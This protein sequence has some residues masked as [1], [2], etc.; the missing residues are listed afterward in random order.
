VIDPITGTTTICSSSTTQLNDVTP[1]G[2]WSSSDNAV[3][4]VDASGLV[5]GTGSGT[6]TISY[7]VTNV[8]NVSTA[9]TSIVTVNPLPAATITADGPTSFCIGGQVILTASPGNSYL[10]SNHETTQSITVNAGGSYHVT[11]TNANNCSATSAATSVTVNPLPTATITAGGAT[12]FCSGD[13]VLLTASAG[14]SYLWNNGAS[15][16]SIR[17]KGSGNYSVTVTNASNC[18]TTSAAVSVTVQTLPNASIAGTTTICQNAPSPIITF[19][20]SKGTAPYTFTYTINGGT[21]QTV[22]SVGNTATVSVPTGTAGTFIYALVSV[23]DASATVCTN[24]ATGSATVTVNSLPTATI[25]GAANVCVN[26]AAPSV[27]FTGANGTV[28][29]T[30]T[31]TINGGTQQTVGSVGNTATVTAPTG[32]AGTFTYALVSVKD[33]SGTLCMNGA[34]GSATVTVNTLPAIS[35]ITGTTTICSG[36][37][38]TLTAASVSAGA[39]FKW[40][41]AASGGNLLFTG[42]TYTTPALT[43]TTTYYVEVTSTPFVCAPAARTA[44][45]VTVNPLPAISG[46]TGT[47]SVCS[48]TTTTLTAASAAGSPV[49]KWYNAASGGILLSTGATYTTPS[50]VANTTYY[51]EVADGNTCISAART[52]VTI[53]VT[54]INNQSVSAAP[55]I[56]CGSGS[57]TISLASSQTGIIYTLRNNANNAAVGTP[58]VGTGAAINFNT[59]TISAS[60]TYN[61]LAKTNTGALQITRPGYVTNNALSLNIASGFTVE[62]WINMADFNNYNTLATQTSGQFP[63]PFDMYVIP[64][65]R[66]LSVLLGNGSGFYNAFASNT[67][68]N[69]ATWYHVA[70]V[71]DPSLAKASLYVNGALDNSMAVTATVAKPANA[72]FRV[73]GRSDNVTNLNGMVDELRIWNAVRTPAQ[74]L[75]NMNSCVT[76]PQANLSL[77]YKFDDAAGSTFAADASGNGL[78]GTFVGITPATAWTGGQINC[79]GICSAQMSA[80]PTVTVNPLPTATISGTAAVCRNAASPTVTFTGANALVAPYTFTYTINGVVQP[81]VTSSGNTATVTVSTG[82]AGIFTYALVSVKD[83]SATPCTNTATGSAVITVNALPVVAAITG[84]TSVCAG[85]TTQLNDA[86]SGGVWSSAT[87]SVATIN[88]TGVVTGVANGTSVITYTVTN[89]NNCI[90]SVSTTVTVNALP[91]VTVTPSSSVVCA[92]SPVTLAANSG[93]GNAMRFNGTNSYVDLGAGLVL[94]QTFTEEAWIYSGSGNDGL[95]H[96]F[97]GFQPANTNQRPPSLWIHNGTEIHGGFGTGSGFYYYITGT[98][99]VQNTWNHIAQTYDGTTLRVYVNGVQITTLPTNLQ[100]P[101]NSIPFATGVKNI[102]RVDN[103]F[104]G[105]MDEVRLWNVTRTP[106]Q[107]AYDMNKSVAPDTAG[108]VGYYQF[109]E[110]AGSTTTADAT[111]GGRTGTLTNGPAFVVSSAPVGATITWSPSTGLNT[112]IGAIAIAQPTSTTTYTA[113][114]TDASTGCVSTA[115]SVITVNPL[116]TATISGATN[117][118]INS[119]APPVTF[120][121]AN[122]TAPYTFTYNINGG[123]QQTVVSAGNTA[124]VSAP[125]GTAGTFTYALVSVRD[126]STSLCSNTVTGSTLVVVRAVSTISGITGT[127][128]IC[129]GSSTTLTAA[130]AFVGPLF[131]WYD[132]ASGGNL[133]FTGAA[134]TTAAL[135]GTTTYYVELTSTPFVCAPAPRTAVTVTVNTLPTFTAC[136]S[137]QNVNAT[138]GL[139]TS[140]LTYTATAAGTPAPTLSYTFTGATTGTGSGTGSGQTFNKGVTTVTITATNSCGAVNCIFTVTVADNQ[141]PVFVGTVAG[142]GVPAGILANVPEASQF[143][144]V[145]KLPIPNIAN[146]DQGSIIPY[147]INNAASLASAS[148][149]RIAYYLEL[150]NKWVWVSM[151]KFTSNVALTGIP[152]GTTT[153]QQKVNNLNVLS[154]AGAGVVNG[155]NIATGNIEFWSYCYTQGNAAAIP[156]ASAAVYDFGDAM[157]ANVDCYGSFQVH[158]YGALETVFA[159]NRWSDIGNLVSDLGIGN[160]TGSVNKDYTFMSN[161]NGYSVKNL[162]VFITNG[163]QNITANAGAG[164]CSAIVSVPTPTATDNCGTPTVSGVRSDNL[165][166]S[167]AYPKGVTTITWTATDASGNASTAS[168]TVTVTDNQPPVIACTGNISLN[169]TSAAG[170]AVTYTAPVGTDN[171]PGAVTVRTAGL[172]SGSTFPIGTTTVTH[173][174]T[175]ASGLTATCS[176]TV[177]V[178]GLAPVIHCPANITVNNAAGQC[179]ANVSF[180]ATETTAIPASTITYSIAP[181]SFFAVGTQRL[182]QRQP[183]LWAHRTAH[184]Q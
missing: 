49:F 184:L 60:T 128:T 82:A 173:R 146:W 153:F 2:V 84:T 179:G 164:Q 52:A 45:T 55:A 124:T 102:G 28:P 59:G 171:C 109:S 13:S 139:C 175:D 19:T 9:V 48:G 108:L 149:S 89:A 134:Y 169:A 58:V 16:P 160:N 33:A 165:A 162:Y 83:A 116:P 95:F 159:Y 43:N 123:T 115:T 104:K 40:Y 31:Y 143:Q 68:F 101:L 17:A 168:Q 35:G 18:S 122:G 90:A 120:T 131:K 105:D 29:Y 47:T 38:T 81:T 157:N 23:K 44:V 130:S 26:S 75:A 148:F 144:M 111:S 6:V 70:I 177:T 98:V 57:S 87:G 100:P 11:V 118:C 76:T 140:P 117:V 85:S 147:S 181:G 80:T 32:T 126:A 21:Q 112:T 30:F 129:S 94:P 4:S 107:I 61:V 88:A 152:T 97:L 63:A 77:Y 53:S 72:T 67:V 132:A 167:A 1:G 151:D 166:I 8:N 156:G 154:S 66:Q 150:D 119:A 183:M 158:N 138:A 42:P 110:N 5:T 41:D 10:W 25:S 137:N 71:Y 79:S 91:I 54:T 39:V 136:P 34:T 145:Y 127:T 62:G 93:G 92:G 103:Y 36:S 106:A 24:S 3:A 78:N 20:A 22:G 172:A 15:T 121:G 113:T 178:A 170:A 86:T 114:A 7:T 96:G 163:I 155:N 174:V 161:A 50:L 182:P 142:A 56:I 65:S 37:S 74:I 46:V 64:G 99:I 14:T 135:T 69:A 180:A 73:A 133:L 176:F 12:T 51:V 141:A 27:T 125:T